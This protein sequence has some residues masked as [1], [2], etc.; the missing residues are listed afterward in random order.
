LSLITTLSRDLVQVG[1]KVAVACRKSSIHARTRI[2]PLLTL[3]TLRIELEGILLG[4]LLR[5]RSLL[6]SLSIACG[7]WEVVLVR[8]LR[9]ALKSGENLHVTFWLGIVRW[10][11]THPLRL[12]D[13]SLIILRLIVKV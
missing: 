7:G 4:H 13:K 1:I 3:Q 2:L 5:K 6:G 8:S 12:V 9:W 11:F 10:N